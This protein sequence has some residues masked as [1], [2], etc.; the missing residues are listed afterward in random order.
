M[1]V[2]RIPLAIQLAIALVLG[3]VAG[4]VLGERAR[5]LG[6]VAV[7]VIKL[8]K[9]LAGPLVFFA[10]LDAF[11]RTSIEPRRGLKLLAIS[12]TNA[13]VAA[14]IALAVSNLFPLGRSV[15]RAAFA[16]APE[17]ALEPPPGMEKT[18]EGLVPASLVEPFVTGNALGIVLLA[19]LFGIALR[20]LPDD[21]RASLGRA[22]G[23]SFRLLVL[24]LGWVVKIVPLAA[25]CILAKVIG[26]TG[27]GVF[28]SLLSFVALVTLGIAIHAGVY[29][30]ALLWSVT[31]VAP[32]RFFPA[33]AEAL[34][35]AFSTGSSLATLPITLR[36]LDRMNVTPESAR[37]AAC[38]GTNLNHDGILLYEAMAALFLAQA[39]GHEVGIEKQLWIVGTS[40]LAAVGIGGVPDAGLITLSLVLG[41]VGLPIE[42]VPILLPVDWFLGRLRATAN[43]TSDIV[44]A[45][46]LDHRF[47]EN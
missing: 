35:T 13:V 39:L 14:T 9:A 37:L 20:R 43:V 23:A 4:E 15:D 24:V 44:V 26:T 46:L 17:R 34:L 25:F 2:P 5:P 41:S 36:T 12:L 8:L 40:A 22:I 38:V 30:G 10:I 7:L 6:E 28:R 29:Y 27:F 21:E 16:T 18:I 42:L 47:G 32:W 3:T 11:A 31:R 45:R 1:S 19:L 33:A